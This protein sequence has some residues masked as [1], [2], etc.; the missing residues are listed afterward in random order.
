M[1]SLHKDENSSN[2]KIKKVSLQSDLEQRK[3]G[4]LKDVEWERFKN[5]ENNWSKDKMTMWLKVDHW[6]LGIWILPLSDSQPFRILLAYL[7]FI[8]LIIGGILDKAQGVF[9]VQLNLK[10]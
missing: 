1:F 4:R 8:E 2:L 6:R 7:I 10:V 5:S 3:W 9:S